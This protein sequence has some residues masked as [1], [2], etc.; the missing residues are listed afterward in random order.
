MK[1]RDIAIIGYAETKIEFR[2]GR[3]V[4]DLAGEAMAG[5]LAH[6]GIDKSEID[7][8]AVSS[9]FADA[10]NPFYGPILSAYLGLELD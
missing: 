1:N 10:G 5:A 8:M 9:S 3:S 4:Y 6:A 7:G 2:S